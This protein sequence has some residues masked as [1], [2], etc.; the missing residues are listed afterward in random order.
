MA[1]VCCHAGHRGFRPHFSDTL[2]RSPEATRHAGVFFCVSRH[3]P[4]EPQVL[5]PGKLRQRPGASSSLRV[6]LIAT[7]ATNLVLTRFLRSVPH[8]LGP[9]EFTGKTVVFT[10]G[11][12]A[13]VLLTRFSRAVSQYDPCA[14]CKDCSLQV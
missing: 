1:S 12:T 4:R 3:K 6:T 2:A 5:A 9:V 8:C 11:A 13:G 14:S 10:A 7:L